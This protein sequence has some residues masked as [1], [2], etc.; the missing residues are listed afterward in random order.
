MPEQEVPSSESRSNSDVLWDF[1]NTFSD[2]A[3]V[4]A[5]K[6]ATDSSFRLDRGEIPFD[7]TTINLSQDRDLL[8]KA[9]HDEAIPKLPLKLQRQLLTDARNVSNQLSAMLAGT[10][11][12]VQFIS[13]VDELTTT[14]WYSNLQNMSGEILGFYEKLEQVKTLEKSLRDLEHRANSFKS[15]EE[16]ATETLL[17]L[18]ETVKNA[19]LESEKVKLV[20]ET[21]SKGVEKLA[22]GQAVAL[23]AVASAQQNERN[24]SESAATARAGAGEISSLRTQATTSITELEGGR[25]GYQALLQELT[26]SRTQWDAALRASLDSHKQG[27]ESEKAIDQSER[28][29]LV[30]LIE[31]KDA[32]LTT[33]VNTTLS[34]AVT[35]FSTQSASQLAV[36]KTAFESEAK[37]F[38][39]ETRT[40]LD[41]LEN[42]SSSIVEINTQKTTE[43]FEALQK[44]ESLISEKIRLATNFQLFHSFQTRQLALAE[45]V[46]YWQNALFIAVGSSV[47]LSI[48]FVIWILLK[49]PTYNAAFFLKL[50][51]TI[52]LV[53]A[54]HFCSTRFSE[55]RR[56]EEE[57]AFKSNIS[58]SLEP[59]RELVEK[60]INKN[61]PADATKYLDFVL[62]SID[63][64][65]TSP[66][67]LETREPIAS[68]AKD[69]PK[70]E[71]LAGVKEG[72]AGITKVIA[73]L[74]ELV[75]TVAKLK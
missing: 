51:F 52:P 62:A 32:A 14:I 53:Y 59:Y 6:K 2:E 39:T 11:A 22:Q 56:L 29:R 12:V 7:E 57:Y 1:V 20:V 67:H 75:Q 64:V 37:K 17:R 23:A 70:V 74:N 8:L 54:I 9:I 48:L 44:L 68:E 4:A 60:L 30:K 16:S 41:Q 63:K 66:T 45:S 24:T 65:F 46:K 47:G 5:R 36:S 71:I 55:E 31:D 28:K 72:S 19:E 25:T 49:S 58:I 35:G 3:Q 40:K 69:S 21:A 33:L 26:T 10:D 34:T 50:S 13:A 42:H 43:R 27:F 61:D 73:S 18:M 38:L 15:A